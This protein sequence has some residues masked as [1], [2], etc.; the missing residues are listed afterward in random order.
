MIPIRPVS[1]IHRAYCAADECTPLGA[2]NLLHRAEP[3]R[4]QVGDVLIFLGL[5]RLAPS[6]AW[7]RSALPGPTR[8][9][10]DWST[11]SRRAPDVDVAAGLDEAQLPLLSAAFACVADQLAETRGGVR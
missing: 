4:L 9:A 3:I 2:D 5:A 6:T 7:A 11:W 1:I 8:H 10:C